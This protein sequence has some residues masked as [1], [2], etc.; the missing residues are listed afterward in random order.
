MAATRITLNR[1]SQA[2]ERGA[3]RTDLQ[4]AKKK[5]LNCYVKPKTKSDELIIADGLCPK[6]AE[7]L[8]GAI[9]EV[10]EIGRCHKPIEKIGRILRSRENEGKV[11]RLHIVAHGS[12]G[13][14]S[15]GGTTINTNYLE[16]NQ[17]ELQEWGVNEI[18]L[19]SCETGL[20]RNSS[21]N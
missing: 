18:S 4:K 3:Y 9:H 12:P 6:I 16:R 5:P 20:D 11:K 8:P 1:N 2:C 7:L 14:I 19:F 10:Q 13:H 21:K 17:K 15:L